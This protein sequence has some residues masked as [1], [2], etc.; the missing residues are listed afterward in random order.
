MITDFSDPKAVLKKAKQYILMNPISHES[1]P[2]KNMTDYNIVGKLTGNAV[3]VES[4]KTDKKYMLWNGD[5]KIHFG[6]MGYED[7]TKHKDTKRRESYLL[8][9]TNIRGNWKSDPYS[10]NNLSI[11]LLW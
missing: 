3:L 9:A 5:K 2:L 6:Q 7:Y 11:H 4:D 8:R 1:K 10:P